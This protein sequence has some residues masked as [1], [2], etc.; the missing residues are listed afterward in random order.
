MLKNETL[1]LLMNRE[2]NYTDIV[3]V[4]MGKSF[5]VQKRLINYLGQYGR[6]NTDVTQGVLTL[7]DRSFDVEYIGTTSKS[8]NFWYSAELEKVIPEK[9][10]EMVANVRKTL[11]EIGLVGLAEPKIVLEGGIN[12]YQ[13]SMIYCAFAPQNVGCYCGSGDLTIYMYM[14]NLPDELFR[15]INSAEFSSMVP[16][17]ISN[18]NVKHRLLV[19]AILIENEIEYH[20]DNN[21][22]IAKFNEQS[23][24]TIEFGEN[25][26]IKS[27][28]GNLSL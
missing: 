16:Q 9:Y 3:S 25:D 22:I 12:A 27:I 6:W 23:V 2:V 15:K 11:S 5:I 20:K 26:L 19:E 7:D 1:Q 13:L 21:N 18:S 24:L 28:N 8:D 10:T 17:I 14:K 4:A